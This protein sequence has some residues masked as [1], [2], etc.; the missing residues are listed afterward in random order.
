MD[1]FFITL[2]AFGIFI[3]AMAIGVIIGNRRIQGSCGGPDG[4]KLCGA[5]GEEKQGDNPACLRQGR[6]SSEL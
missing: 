6:A 5:D 1:I 3:F 4:C 2:G